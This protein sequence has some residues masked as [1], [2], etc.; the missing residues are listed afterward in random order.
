[1]DAGLL[2]ILLREVVVPLVATVLTVLALV[3]TVLAL[4]ATV[5]TVLALVLT[6]LALVLTVLRVLAVVLR[7][8]TVVLGVWTLVVVLVVADVTVLRFSRLVTVVVEMV[9]VVEV[10]KRCQNGRLSKRFLDESSDLFLLLK[11]KL[12]FKNEA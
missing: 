6:V 11:E 7:V 5:L 1:M 4:V 3:L 10:G 8:L 12:H 2:L 9:V